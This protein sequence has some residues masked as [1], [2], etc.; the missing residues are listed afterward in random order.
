MALAESDV[1]LALYVGESFAEVH[2]SHNQKTVHFHRWYL[3]KDGLKGGLSKTLQEAG[4][5]KIEKAFVASRFLEKILSYRL[6]GSV[7]VLTTQGFENWP[8]TRQGTTAADKD[9]K[10]FAG[11]AGALSSA[12]L[13]FPVAERTTTQGVV[14]KAPLATEI[15]EIIEKLKTKQAKRVC[16]HFLNADK[17]PANQSQVQAA[18]VAENFEVFIPQ[19][20]PGPVDEAASWRKNILNASLSGTF[21][22]I[23]EEINAA[24]APYLPDGARAQ[25]V[26][27]E[28]PLF[29]KE[30]R[31]R[32]SSLWGASRAWV[33]NLRRPEAFDLLYLG[34]EQFS[35]LNPRKKNPLWQSP[36]GNVQSE[37]V[38]SRFLSLQ[39]TTA[40]ELS[41]WNELAFSRTPLGYEPGPI[42]M[43]RGQ[44]PTLL[45]L[46]GPETSGI[47]GLD[48]RRSPQGLQKFR[49]QIWAL[50]R[51]TAQPLDSED[52][53]IAAMK[54]YALQRLGADILLHAESKKILC[55]GGLAALFT[56][57]LKKRLPEFEFEVL[58][59][60]E[61]SHLLSQGH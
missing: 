32:L 31:Y 33:Q 35:L 58:P 40:I 6:G 51:G 52:K 15:A 57:E 48:E 19:N 36:W 11:K 54:Q 28:G 24:L 9:N 13:L 20:G 34:L 21:E 29:D 38:Q 16:L 7:A 55:L 8:G 47:K 39:P 30:N 12:D 14:E 4:V 44:V 26:S 25:F 37:Q 5:Q 50:N 17:N 61:T 22:E 42:F 46:W 27:G 45:D 1:T 43:G 3:G 59:E 10:P 23:Q 56:P 18:L 2:L 49:N 60:T 41:S 53:V